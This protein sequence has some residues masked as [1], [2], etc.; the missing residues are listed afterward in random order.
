VLILGAAL[1]GFVSG[2]VYLACS[3]VAL[4]IAPLGSAQ[5]PVTSMR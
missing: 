5:T 3:R 2:V 4:M 1:C